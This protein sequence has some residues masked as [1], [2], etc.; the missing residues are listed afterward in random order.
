MKSLFTII[1]TFLSIFVLAQTKLDTL[2]F[3][4]VNDYRVSMSV[5]ILKWDTTCF[6]ASRIHTKYLVRTGKV[7]HGE[8]SLKEPKERMKVFD[9]KG[10]WTTICEVAL[11]TKPINIKDTDIDI[12]EKLA[13]AVVDGWKSSKDHN[14]ILLDKDVSCKF[15]GVSCKV[16]DKPSGIKGINNYQVFSTMLTVGGSYRKL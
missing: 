1:L 7:G 4:K 2:V 5:P 10:K 3:N 14:D 8:D 15:A 6:N 9:K 13:T 11:S 16:I 12:L